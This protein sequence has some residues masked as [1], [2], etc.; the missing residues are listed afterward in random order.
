MDVRVN[1]KTVVCSE[2]ATVRDLLG[3]L[4]LT[5]ETVVVERNRELV[6]QE[7]FAIAHLEAGDT[8]EVL[9]FVGGG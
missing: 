2:G 4:D 5:P 7:L 3:L 1:G 9:Q 8:L 6:P